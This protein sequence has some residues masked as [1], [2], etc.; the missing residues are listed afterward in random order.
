MYLD[1]VQKPCT[2]HVCIWYIYIYIYLHDMMIM[3]MDVCIYIYM[4]FFKYGVY[5]EIIY[6]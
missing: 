4:L 6:I 2:Y 5:I 1:D 3:M